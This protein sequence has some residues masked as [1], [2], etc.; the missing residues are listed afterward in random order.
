MIGTKLNDRDNGPVNTD[1]NFFGGNI[2]RISVSP[3]QDGVAVVVAVESVTLV[4]FGLDTA[5]NFHAALA[6]GI[7][8]GRALLEET[9]P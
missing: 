3:L 4:F 7:A 9:T 1:I 6:E 8:K 5:E 2:N